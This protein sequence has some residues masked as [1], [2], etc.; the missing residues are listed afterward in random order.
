MLNKIFIMGRL[1]RD[2]ELRR[3]QSGT[4]VTSFSLAVDRDYKS[5]SGE[6]ETDFIDVVAW[7]STAEFVS[8][9]FTKGRMAVVEGRLQIRAWQDKDGNN[10]RSAEVVADNVYFG[11]SRRDGDGGSGG[12]ANNSYGGNGGYSAPAGGYAAPVGGASGF[13]EIDEEDGDLPF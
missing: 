11:D 10:R 8:K 3:T 12:Y 2:P 6:K 5:Q 9:Y 4:P 7:R 13:A 1:T